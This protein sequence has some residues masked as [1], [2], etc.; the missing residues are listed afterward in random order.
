VLSY[1]PVQVGE[2][3]YE[4]AVF[5][6]GL[7]AQAWHEQER[8]YSPQ[9]KSYAAACHC[10]NAWIAADCE[11][12]VAFWD[13][14]SRGSLHTISEA[15]RLGRDCWVYDGAGQLTPCHLEGR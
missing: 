10:R 3:K 8:R 13:G 6:T 5:A 14:V 7:A 9:L 1:R 12:L 4:I 2:G 11:K 15:R